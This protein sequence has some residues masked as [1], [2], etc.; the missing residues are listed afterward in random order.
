MEEINTFGND[1]LLIQ[2][3]NGKVI[4]TTILT[5]QYEIEII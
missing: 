1:F 3:I 5:E 2:F 4:N